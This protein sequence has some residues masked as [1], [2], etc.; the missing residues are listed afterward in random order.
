M[1]ANAIKLKQLI[2]FAKEIGLDQSEWFVNMVRRLSA[3]CNEGLYQKTCDI[4]ANYDLTPLLDDTFPVP[5]SPD[6]RK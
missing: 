3:G 4:L 2:E 1:N 6:D 5:V